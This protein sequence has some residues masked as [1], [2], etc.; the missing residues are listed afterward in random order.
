MAAQ[1]F[2]EQNKVPSNRQLVALTPV[3]ELGQA[4]AAAPSARSFAVSSPDIGFLT[5]LLASKAGLAPYRR[6]RRMEPASATRLYREALTPDAVPAPSPR[7]TR[8]I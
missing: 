1:D 6:A 3:P 5:Q 4:G 7:L 8:L 2:P